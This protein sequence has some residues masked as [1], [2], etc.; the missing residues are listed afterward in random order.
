MHR[1]LCISLWVISIVGC[2]DS[3]VICA[4]L[5]PWAVAVDVR[6]SVTDA[7]LVSEARGAVF[8]AGALDDSLRRERLLHLSSDTLLVGGTTEGLVEVRIESP[9]YLPWTAPDVRTRLSGGDCSN[10]ETQQLVARLQSPPQ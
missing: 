3:Q 7:H 6:D 4:P 2:S 10:W 1:A 8:V 5:P 9:G